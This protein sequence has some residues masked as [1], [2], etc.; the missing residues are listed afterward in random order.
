MRAA[1]PADL[2]LSRREDSVC[3]SV[4]LSVC[5]ERAKA[6]LDALH[7]MPHAIR[8]PYSVINIAGLLYQPSTLM[9]S[10]ASVLVPASVLC[11]RSVQTAE[12]FEGMFPFPRRSRLVLSNL[13]GFPH[14]GAYLIQR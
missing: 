13:A 14:D 10:P 6:P 12:S 5:N 8:V 3:L 9:S 11:G 1:R 4:C 2:R 7:L